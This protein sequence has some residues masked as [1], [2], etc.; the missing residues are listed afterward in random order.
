M[1]IG[2]IVMMVVVLGLLWGGFAVLLV[3]AVRVDRRRARDEGGGSP[4]GPRA[5]APDPRTTPTEV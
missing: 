4:D 3:H 5:G 1:Q 2:T